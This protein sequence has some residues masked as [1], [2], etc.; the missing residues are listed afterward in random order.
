MEE[1]ASATWVNRASAFIVVVDSNDRC[2]ARRSSGR[3][4]ERVVGGRYAPKSANKCFGG[5]RVAFDIK[6]HLRRTQVESLAENVNVAR[7]QR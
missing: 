2:R 4:A 6:F 5:E 3:I 7:H 1:A